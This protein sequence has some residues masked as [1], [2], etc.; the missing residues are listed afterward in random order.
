MRVNSSVEPPSSLTWRIV[1]QL[2]VG[3]RRGGAIQPQHRADAEIGATAQQ[4]LFV[5]ALQAVRHL[6]ATAH[7]AGWLIDLGGA[8]VL[9]A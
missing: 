2:Q 4:R 7:D 5:A 3:G 6:T 9:D 1:E 8:D